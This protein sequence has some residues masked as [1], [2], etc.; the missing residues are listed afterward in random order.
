MPIVVGAVHHRIEVD[1]SR[2]LDIALSIEQQQFDTRSFTRV[3]TE[4][5]AGYTSR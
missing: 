5:Y 3:K 4:I 1:H 2:G